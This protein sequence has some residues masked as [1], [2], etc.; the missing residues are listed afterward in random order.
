VRQELEKSKP[1]TKKQLKNVKKSSP[2]RKYFD[3]ILTKKC[4]RLDFEIN[5]ERNI[6]FNPGLFNLINSYVSILPLWTGCLLSILKT[7][8]KSF[9]FGELVRLHSNPA[10]KNF[11]ILKNKIVLKSGAM[12]SEIAAL[13]YERLKFKYD[14]HYAKRMDEISAE[15]TKIQPSKESD[16]VR[17]VFRNFYSNEN[18]EIWKKE[19]N[20]RKH[21]SFYYGNKSNI[22]YLDLAISAGVNSNR[23]FLDIFSGKNLSD[24]VC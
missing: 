19:N 14:L 16:F 17:D 18:I 12:P 24:K 20:K 2:F 11:D 10:E 6:F 22:T 1:F 5:M 7:T 13:S 23:D 9:E 3:K 4:K 21:G 8:Y 15:F